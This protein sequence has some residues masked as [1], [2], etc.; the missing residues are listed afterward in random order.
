MPIS[1]A[2]VEDNKDLRI[3]TAYVLRSSQAFEVVGAYETAEE[4]IESIDDIQPEVIIMDIELPGI[5]GIEA[6][7]Q[8]KISHPTVQIVILSIFEDDE[9]VFQAICA[10]ACGYITKPVMPD[11]LHDVVEQAFGGSSPMSPHIARKVLEMFKQYIPP[12]KADYR[13]TQREIE[14]LDLLI[15]GFDNKVIAD[16]LFLSTYTVRAHIRNIYDK[17]HVHSK[18]QAVAK[19]LKERLVYK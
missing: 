9:N 3:G 8:I 12:P 13:L 1:V 16:K 2:L 5:N 14:V 10:G 18:S 7:R 11:R 19:A 6:T 4:L 17:L 15:Q